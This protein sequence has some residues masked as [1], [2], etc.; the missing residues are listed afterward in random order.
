MSCIL[1]GDSFLMARKGHFSRA[2]CICKLPEKMILG[3]RHPLNSKYASCLETAASPSPLPSPYLFLI[4]VSF[5]MKL[6]GVK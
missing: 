5:S 2:G 4:L 3:M 1:C 6:A